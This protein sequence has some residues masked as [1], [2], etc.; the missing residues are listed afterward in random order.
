MC[1]YPL[2]IVERFGTDVASAKSQLDHRWK[3]D[4]HVIPQLI[5]NNVSS[6]MIRRFLQSG[7]SVRYLVPD[8][9]L[10]YIEEQSLYIKPDR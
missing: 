10:E 9:V 1:H 3:G 8:E 6:T 7:R 5:Q 2:F 4:I